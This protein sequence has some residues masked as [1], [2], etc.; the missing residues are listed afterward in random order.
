MVDVGTLSIVGSINIESIQ[1]GLSNLKRGLTEAKNAAKSAFGDIKRI[2]S[3]VSKIA[4]PL[5]ILGA[6]I[7]AA[8]TGLATMAP[9]VA[10]HL[11]RMKADFFRLSTIVGEVFEPV[12][13]SMADAFNRF[14]NWLDSP[15]GR[16][17]LTT[18]KNIIVGLAGDVKDLWEKLS[19]LKDKIFE[20][21]VIVNI[22]EKLSPFLKNVIDNYG[23]EA[24]M[25]LVG[26]KIAGLPGALLAGGGT[27]LLRNVGQDEQTVTSVTK[28][29][30]GGG[31]LGAAFG[32]WLGLLFGSLAGAGFETGA[33]LS[34]QYEERFG[35]GSYGSE[36]GYESEMNDWNNMEN[37]HL[38]D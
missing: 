3:A 35:P 1:L 2:G 15:Q 5:K 22:V 34:E 37:A 13:N 20:S 31:A 28:T 8:F 14:V 4:G 18:V 24:L 32:G 36:G 33:W 23:L 29:I 11:E 12:F 10:P 6:G 25:F 38:G 21:D 19:L 30:G 7:V 17:V 16:G 26:W 9:Q 27:A